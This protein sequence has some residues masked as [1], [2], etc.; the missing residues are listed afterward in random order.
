M[1]KLLTNNPLAVEKYQTL[2]EVERVEGAAA[3]V[4]AVVRDYVHL[5]HCLVTHP[6]ASSI[7]RKDSPFKSIAVSK[8]AGRLDLD[9]LRI[10]EGAIDAYKHSVTHFNIP[11]SVAEDF[12][13]IDCEML[14]KGFRI[15]VR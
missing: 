9:S 3:D 4:L 14:S 13:L 8:E 7:P 12:M 10:I 2:F 6:L 1:N 11:T 15:C 5:G